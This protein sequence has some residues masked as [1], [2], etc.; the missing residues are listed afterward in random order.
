[1]IPN[2]HIA[3][4]VKDAVHHYKTFHPPGRQMYIELIKTKKDIPP[5]SL[6]NPLYYTKKKA[7]ISL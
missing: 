1:M 5:A 2:T 6:G 3:D 7:W 4:L